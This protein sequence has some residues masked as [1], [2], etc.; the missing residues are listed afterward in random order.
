[1]E[2]Q[3]KRRLVGLVVLVLAVVVALPLLFSGPGG[4]DPEGATPDGV[5]DSPDY[6]FK[7]IEI[8]LEV[9]AKEP[10]EARR[11]VEPE[12]QV[13]RRSGPEPA[14]EPQTAPAPEAK[15]EPEPAASPSEP[16]PEAVADEE[17]IPPES[18]PMPAA[19]QQPAGWVV[20]VGS[21]TDAD[22]AFGLRDKL[23]QAGFT[24]FVEE[25]TAEGNQ[26]Y[27]VRVGPEQEEAQ[28]E[29]LKKRLAS[30]MDL[31]GLVMRYP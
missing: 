12:R 30:G 24:T 6:E 16:E 17:P 29:A 23:R 15:A 8:P 26:V 11:V 18:A 3:L 19:P 27:R 28:A 20:Q 14:P 7:T 1:M 4:G 31:D 25:V 5:P 22:N 9:P 10:E 21:F 2:G 13:E